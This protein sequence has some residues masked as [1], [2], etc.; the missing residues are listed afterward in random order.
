MP[1]NGVSYGTEVIEQCIKHVAHC[2]SDLSE[3]NRKL[4]RIHLA[5]ALRETRSLRTLAESVPKSLCPDKRPWEE[6]RLK[7]NQRALKIL[8]AI[9]LQLGIVNSAVEQ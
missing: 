6:S 3:D 2:L 5:T 9:E 7:Q 1:R 4:V 8:D